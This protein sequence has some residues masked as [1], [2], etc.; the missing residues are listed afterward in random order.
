MAVRGERFEL[1]LENDDGLSAGPPLP[2]DFSLIG[3]I[4][5]RSSAAPPSAPVFKQSSTGF[6]AHRKRNKQSAFKQ[7]SRPDDTSKPGSSPQSPGQKLP[8]DRAI[9]EYLKR[10]Y[11]TKEEAQK[12]E[13]DKENNER[14]ARMSPEDIEQERSELLSGLNPSLI[15]RLLKRANIDEDDASNQGDVKS[16]KDTASQEKQISGLQDGPH[17]QSSKAD[18]QHEFTP[19]T[20]TNE[21][22]TPPSA[23]V[24][25]PPPPQ[26]PKLDPA[27]STFLSD[28]QTH[29][30]PNTPHDPSSLSWLQPPTSE[31]SAASVYNP[32]NDNLPISQ[33]RYNFRGELLS[34]TTSLAIPVTEG[35]HH[36]GEAPDSAGYTIPELSILSRSA[37]PAQRCVAW[38]VLGRILYRLGQGM[39]GEKGTELADGIWEVVEGEKVVAGMIREAD[40]GTHA[41]ARTWATE[42]VW[43]WR[44]GGGGDRGLLREGEMRIR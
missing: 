21:P 44:K 41:S 33:L 27:S 37:L 15:A 2:S 39:Y 16:A 7:K 26:A 4:R 1:D 23:S 29:Y 14:L 25:F 22:L 38:Q 31:E 3:E 24:H 11:G 40:R 12:A 35:L 30:F 42:G 5:E 36:H 10:T 43:L 13:I 8:S 32:A 17:L 34:P 28:L 20:E 6:P 9:G 19:S 18:H